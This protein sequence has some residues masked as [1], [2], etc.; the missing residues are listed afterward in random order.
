M[1]Y[2][3]NLHPGIQTV[4]LYFFSIDLKLDL[5]ESLKEKL[6]YIMAVTVWLQDWRK[7]RAGE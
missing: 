7:K 3:E 2:W 1:F 6:K 4:I 5:P